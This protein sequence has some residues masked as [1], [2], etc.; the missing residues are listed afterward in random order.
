MSC[1]TNTRY[2]FESWE[3][4][5]NTLSDLPIII[6]KYN[7][8]F[9]DCNKNL[10]LEEVVNVRNGQFNCMGFAFGRL[11]CLSYGWD[12]G[13]V[14]TDAYSIE[15]DQE[16]L[17]LPTLRII[18]SENELKDNEYLVAFRLAEDDFH[19]L[20][21]FDDGKWYEKSGCCGE[22]LEYCNDIEE[23]WFSQFGCIEYDSEIVYF[24]VEKEAA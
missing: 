23:T 4:C 21:K 18:D 7:I 19:F 13:D 20:R 22:V 11:G 9:K 6:E 5:A 3:E 24:A 17:G 10:S 12:T 15:E 2:D 16:I 1:N 14:W 8:P